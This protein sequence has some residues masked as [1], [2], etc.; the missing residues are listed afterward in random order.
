VIVVTGGGGKADADVDGAFTPAAMTYS[1]YSAVTV[2]RQVPS[3]LAVAD[4]R[5]RTSP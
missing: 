1:T 3:N 5:R 2:E 4:E